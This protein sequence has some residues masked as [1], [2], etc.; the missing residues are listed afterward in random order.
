MNGAA[1]FLIFSLAL[2]LCMPGR[3]GAEERLAWNG[4]E[5]DG[6]LCDGKELKPKHGAN[7]SNTWV[8]QNGE[9]K[10]KFGANSSNTWVFNGRELKPKFG[11]NSSNTWILDGNKLKPKFGA[12]SSNTWN[13]GTAP[14]LVIA[15]KAV[16]RLF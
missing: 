5:I 2:I 3:S 13:V 11:A 14:I 4:K 8:Y 10:P 12:N 7:S 9:I 16:L 1:F 15:G 6:W